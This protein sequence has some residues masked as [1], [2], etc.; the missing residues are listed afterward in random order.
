M[1]HHSGCF[2]N[3]KIEWRGNLPL[4]DRHNVNHNHYLVLYILSLKEWF[5]NYAKYE[6]L[7]DKIQTFERLMVDKM[8]VLKRLI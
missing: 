5:D 1:V 2:E 8:Q 6:K 4:W 7:S 3:G